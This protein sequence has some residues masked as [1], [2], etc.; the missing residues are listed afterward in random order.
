MVITV[1]WPPRALTKLSAVFGIALAIS[2]SS[3][4]AQSSAGFATRPYAPVVQA[5]VQQ[6]QRPVLPPQSEPTAPYLNERRPYS[7]VAQSQLDAQTMTPDPIPAWNPASKDDVVAPPMVA[8]GPLDATPRDEPI[9]AA[10][11]RAGRG[12]P[13]TR[14]RPLHRGAISR[15]IR[16]TGRGITYDLPEGVANNLPWVD[17]DRKTEPFE[18]VLARVADDLNRA[19]HTDPQWAFGAQR[20]IRELSKRLDRLPEPP[21]MPAP[22]QTAQ[23]AEAEPLAG[24]SRP[25]RPRPIWPGASGR[26]EEQVRPSTIVTHTG[27]QSGPRSEGVTAVFDPNMEA[28]GEAALGAQRPSRPR[29]Q[30]PRRPSHR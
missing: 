28:E 6:A 23:L 13:V 25:F 30:T 15:I 17:R 22:I 29:M 18:A 20:E 9:A 8:D 4:N 5:P 11:P 24:Q 3:A 1:S 27:L 2:P 16:D 14:G 12:V 10:R 19:T 26:P 21:P 7:I